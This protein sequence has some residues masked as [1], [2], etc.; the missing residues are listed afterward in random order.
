METE[1]KKLTSSEIDQMLEEAAVYHVEPKEPSNKDKKNKK[2]K[3]KRKQIRFD[4]IIAI[5]LAVVVVVG[6]VFAISKLVGKS[7]SA[8]KKSNVENPLEDDKYDEITDVVNNYLNAYLVE[9]SQKRLDILARYVDN[10]GDLSESDIAQKKY[11]TSYSEVECYTKNGPY[12]NTYVVYAYYQTEYKNISTKVPSLTTYYVIRDAK[13]GNVYI[14]NK[15]SDEIKD[16]ISKVSKD[17]DVQKLISDVQKELLEA[18]KSDANLKKFLDALTGKTEETT[19]AAQKATQ[20]TTQPATAKQEQ[21]TTQATK[22][23]ATTKPAVIQKATTAKPTEAPTTTAE[24]R[25]K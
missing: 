6:A 23:A 24:A 12:D 7:S 21:K 15:W 8:S 5:V 1:E 20:A 18:V 13:T 9:D 2:K 25:I 14:H 10:I 16:Y 4:I 22:Q 11:I 17:A 19:T 3:K